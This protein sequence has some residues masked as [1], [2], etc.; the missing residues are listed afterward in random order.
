MWTA[1]PRTSPLET[2]GIFVVYEE[3]GRGIRWEF[4]PAAWAQRACDVAGRTL[5]QDEWNRFL[6]GLPYDPACSSTTSG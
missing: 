5:T 1:I 2:K 6:P 3:T 4:D